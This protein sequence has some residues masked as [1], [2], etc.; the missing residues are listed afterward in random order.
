MRAPYDVNDFAN[1]RLDHA[2]DLREL[3][4]LAAYAICD[5]PPP[6]QIQTVV[7]LL[8]S[9]Y[10]LLSYSLRSI[11]LALH[12]HLPLESQFTTRLDLFAPLLFKDV[13][14]LSSPSSNIHFAQ[15]RMAVLLTAL[16]VPYLGAHFAA[17]PFCQVI[18]V[19]LDHARAHA[20]HR[21]QYNLP[22]ERSLASL[23]PLLEAL[24][25]PDGEDM[26]QDLSVV[27]PFE[28]VLHSRLAS[29]PQL[30]LIE[31]QTLHESRTRTA[32]RILTDAISQPV[33]LRDSRT[34]NELLGEL[35][36][37]EL[38]Y[39]PACLA[40]PALAA[41][42]PNTA[43]QV[44]TRICELTSNSRQHHR[45]ST[46][47][48]VDTHTLPDLL[49]DLAHALDP[50]PLRSLDLVMRL[51]RD[52]TPAFC[53]LPSSTFTLPGAS[54]EGDDAVPI[55]TDLG[56]I[57]QIVLLGPFLHRCITRL[58][59]AYASAV[60]NNTTSGRNR[61]VQQQQ[62]PQPRP[63]FEE[64]DVRLLQK[65]TRVEH[66]ANA[67][68]INLWDGTNI[69][70]EHIVEGAV[71]LL[72]VNT[73]LKQLMGKG[74]HVAKLNPTVLPYALESSPPI[75]DEVAWE[76]ELRNFCQL[77]RALLTSDTIIASARPPR[78]TTSHPGRSA[79][80]SSSSSS[81]LRPEEEEVASALHSHTQ[82]VGLAIRVELRSFM[83]E[84]GR[85]KA[86]NEVFKLLSD[87][88]IEFA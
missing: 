72:M 24:A 84:R 68:L 48:H 61:S 22:P 63:D 26:I 60:T 45:V 38:L 39:S 27:T 86:A 33:G 12:A 4:R 50:S 69:T 37:N 79:A 17:R 15:P 71:P 3:N 51:V 8:L 82:S 23:R 31:F 53:T 55:G 46:L 66:L 75:P 14:A 76:R 70:D 32:L 34:I 74:K 49:E 52:Q 59:N 87:S 41:R 64:H 67:A 19:L 56:L 25:P 44:L 83:L 29:N 80:F 1:T 30:D 57:T 78:I 88:E 10:I 6:R 13:E 21:Q 85:Y 28:I 9:P 7:D 18:S 43:I 36:F 81:S 16:Q 47:S 40:F 11:I 58:S 77:I 73:S 54:D 65:Q 62:A 5:T 20:Q 42:N 2:Q 35:D